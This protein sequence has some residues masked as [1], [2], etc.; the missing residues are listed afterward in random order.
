M[1]TRICP[2][3][4]EEYTRKGPKHGWTATCSRKCA[5][6][7]RR[8]DLAE[9]LW[10]RVDTS[11]GEDSC[12]EWQGSRHRQGYGTMGWKGKILKTHRVAYQISHGTL[13]SSDDVLHTCDNPPCC[14]PAH[15][16]VGN[17]D[18]NMKDMK[19]KGRSGDHKGENNG[20]ARISSADVCTIRNA[21]KEPQAA[22]MRRFG[23]TQSAISSIQRRITWTHITCD[24]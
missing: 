2:V 12:W 8:G 17:H 6:Q 19:A 9:A 23:L 16:F 5:W 10:R 4:H 18:T 15:L 22:L 21:K 20:R 1:R 13:L 14:N 3:C 24:D 11:R 7:Q